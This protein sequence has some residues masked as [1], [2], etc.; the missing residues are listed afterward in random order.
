MGGLPGGTADGRTESE[1]VYG[2]W[3]DGFHGTWSGCW[4]WDAACCLL[5]A[6][7]TTGLTW[8]DW[9][10]GALSA[11]CRAAAA[12]SLGWPAEPWPWP[13]DT[14]AITAAATAAVTAAA[15]IVTRDRRPTRLVA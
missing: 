7:L 15:P 12:R 4:C 6:C 11:P 10:A 14:P 2:W 9:C 13:D 3:L 1:K 8:A 5:G